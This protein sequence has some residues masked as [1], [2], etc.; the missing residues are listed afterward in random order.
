MAKQ[1]IGNSP[2]NCTGG[3]AAKKYKESGNETIPRL[4]KLFQLRTTNA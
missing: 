3:S 2:K 1:I 4:K